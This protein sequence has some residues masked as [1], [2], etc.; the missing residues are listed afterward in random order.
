MGGKEQ[1]TWW[2]LN[3]GGRQVYGAQDGVLVTVLCMRECGGVV[4]N[5]AGGMHTCGEKLVVQLSPYRHVRQDDP[6]PRA[7]E[8]AVVWVSLPCCCT[9]QV[10]SLRLMKSCFLV[11]VYIVKFG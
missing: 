8:E 10:Q 3:E 9:H 11:A 1:T 5:S 4:D 7:A 6:S 2:W